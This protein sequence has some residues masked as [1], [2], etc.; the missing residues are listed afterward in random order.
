MAIKHPSNHLQASSQI[1][2]F[3]TNLKI[4]R[5]FGTMAYYVEVWHEKIMG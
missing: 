3:C 1:I 2:L 5:S 4:K